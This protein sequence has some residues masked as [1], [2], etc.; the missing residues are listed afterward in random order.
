MQFWVP[1]LSNQS[2]LGAIFAWIFGVCPDFHQIKTFGGALAP[3]ASY[4][5]DSVTTL[6][7]IIKKYSEKK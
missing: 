2:T 3:P 1:F 7:S 6:I 5:T 4:A